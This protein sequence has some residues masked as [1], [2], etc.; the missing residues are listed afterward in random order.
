[1]LQTEH[2]DVALRYA[3]GSAQKNVVAIAS[4]DYMFS[5]GLYLEA[6]E[7]YGKSSKPFEQVALTFVDNDQQDALRKYLLTKITTFK[8][9]YIIFVLITYVANELID[10][11]IRRPDLKPRNLIPALLN[12]DRDFHGPLLQNQAVRY[13]LNV[14]YQQKSTDAAV[15]NTLIVIYA[16]HSSKDESD[17][18]IYLETQGDEPSFDFDFA[19]SIELALVHSEIELA[20]MIADSPVSNP[21][22]RKKLWLLV[23][24]KKISQSSSTKGTIEL[25]KRC[26]L[27]SI[28][29]LIPFF[30]DFVVIDDFK[31]EVCTVL[32]NRSWNIDVL[33]REMDKSSQMIANIMT[34]IAAL[35]H[36]YA[37][38]VPGERC[39]ICNLPLLSRQFFVFLC[40]HAFH[41]DCLEEKVVEQGVLGNGKRI[42]ELQLSVSKGLGRRAKR[43]VVI[44][45]LDGLVASA[46][47][48][49]SDFAVKQIDEPIM[50]WRAQAGID[51]SSKMTAA[52]DEEA[53]VMLAIDKEEMEEKL[54][55]LPT[56]AKKL[57]AKEMTAETEQGRAISETFTKN[58]KPV[59]ERWERLIIAAGSE[60]EPDVS[61]EELARFAQRASNPEDVRAYLEKWGAEEVNLEEGLG[62]EEEEEEDDDDDIEVVISEDEEEEDEDEDEEMADFIV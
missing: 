59:V 48:L 58:M 29:D 44:V 5:K 15:H 36:R 42:K 51:A 10:F 3:R 16:L 9:S 57:A 39:Y 30:P 41:S 56:E 18:L 6:V 54:K 20:S 22:L 53:A 13:L 45:D 38:V 21:A 46:C 12:Y 14:I 61:E 28:E 49:C 32:E 43:D 8:K 31:E 4:G 23:A 40:Q 27:L 25:L 19:L 7:V 60:L 34:D 26:D 11:L 62:E 24:K 1:M 37:I 2:F 55:N 50:D 33:N 47:I 35:D 17:L 52:A